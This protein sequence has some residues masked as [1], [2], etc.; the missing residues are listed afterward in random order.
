MTWEWPATDGWAPGSPD[1]D[2]VRDCEEVLDNV[3]TALQSQHP[4]VAIEAE[5]IEGHPAYQLVKASD[6]EDLLVVGSRVRGEFADVLLGSVSEYC[7]ANA[8]SCRG[9]SLCR[10]SSCD[11]QG[12]PAQGSRRAA[13][14]G[15]CPRGAGPDRSAVKSTHLQSAAN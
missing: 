6:R 9:G 1:H 7:V 4:G 3:L 15:R 10:L 14:D 11:C 12:L 5:V 13:L 2:P 8:R